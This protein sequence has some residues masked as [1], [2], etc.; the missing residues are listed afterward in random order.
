VAGAVARGRQKFDPLKKGSAPLV[1]NFSQPGLDYR[2]HAV[3]KYHAAAFRGGQRKVI[4]FGAGKD[5]FR[6][7]KSRRP[8]VIDLA[9]IPADVIGMN[10][11]EQN[12]VDLP[13]LNAKLF[14][15]DRKRCFEEMEKFA[16][17]TLLPVADPR[18]DHENPAAKFH[19]P[20]IDI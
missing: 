20:D 18:V 11:G 13:G 17:R 3:F 5:I 2:Q 4:P 1:D 19:H 12:V 10:V 6:V 7:R 8:S 14:E 9:G 15:L 16:E